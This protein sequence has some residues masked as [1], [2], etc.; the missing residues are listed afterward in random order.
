MVGAVRSIFTAE[1]FHLSRLR[2]L[3]PNGNYALLND[4]NSA[5]P[6]GEDLQD[7]WYGPAS[8]FTATLADIESAMPGILDALAK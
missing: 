2:Q 3:H 5:M 8:G 4:F 6:K 1:D 7:P